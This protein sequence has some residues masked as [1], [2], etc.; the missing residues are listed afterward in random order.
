MRRCSRCHKEK[1]LTDFN[2]KNKRRGWRQYQCK[3][4]SRFYIRS[5]YIKN[6][7]YYLLKAHKRNKRIRDEIRSFIWQYLSNHACVDCGEKDPIVLEFDHISDKKTE[8]SNMH[9]NYTLA[10]VKEEIKKCQ[11][12]CANCHRRKTA[13]ELGWNKKFLPL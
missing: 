9:R 10:K 1:A 6:K 2:F 11:I 7:K 8:I 12:R 3:N 4:C 5:H 13:R